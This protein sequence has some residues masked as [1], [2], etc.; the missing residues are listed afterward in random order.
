[1]AKCVI[2]GVR[3]E[4]NRALRILPNRKFNKKKVECELYD[5]EAYKKLRFNL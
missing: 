3:T 1:M 5:Y 2:W 4:A